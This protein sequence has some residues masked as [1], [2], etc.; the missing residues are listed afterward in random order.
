MI[1]TMDWCSSY[2]CRPTL[3]LRSTVF[4]RTG[5]YIFKGAFLPSHPLS[6]STK[7][8]TGFFVLD[9]WLQIMLCRQARSQGVRR[10]TPKSAKRSTFRYKVDQK[11]GFCRRVRGVSSKRSTFLESRTFP[12][13]IEPKTSYGPVCSHFEYCSL[14]DMGQHVFHVLLNPQQVCWVDYC[15]HGLVFMLYL[16]SDS[17][18]EKY[19]FRQDW[20]L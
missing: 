6:K 7:T 18:A 1:A 20:I 14:L 19:C 10:T 13:F 11:W 5:Y 2:I 15:H 4:G 16:P 17:W 3:G 12:K 9:G 8:L